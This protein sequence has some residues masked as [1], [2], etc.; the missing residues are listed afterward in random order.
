MHELSLA[1]SILEIAGEQ[2]E[3]RGGAVIRAIHLRLGPLAGVVKHALVSAFDLAREVSSCP[4]SEL[5]IEEVPLVAMCPQC[6]AQQTLASCQDLSC[7]VC[8][9]PCANLIS[10][11]ELEIVAMEIDA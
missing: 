3:M 1:M 7:P 2:S 5:V 6:D 8:G 4:D 11:R 10:G 9:T